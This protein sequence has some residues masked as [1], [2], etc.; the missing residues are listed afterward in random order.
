MD[1]KIIPDKAGQP[2]ARSEDENHDN[3]VHLCGFGW[4]AAVW[5]GL[6]WGD[7]E[8]ARWKLKLIDLCQL[9]PVPAD[10][11]R[12]HRSRRFESKRWGQKKLTRE[13]VRTTEKWEFLRP[14]L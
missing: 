11:S 5:R 8:T 3:E 12:G 2:L 7:E 10:F 14:D 9:L 13:P 4:F 1:A 6:A